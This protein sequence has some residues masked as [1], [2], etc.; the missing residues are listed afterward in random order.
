MN[1][2]CR[3]KFH[4]TRVRA[5]SED[6]RNDWVEEI[7][8]A[9]IE[10]KKRFR[11]PEPDEDLDE[12]DEELPGDVEPLFFPNSLSLVCQVFQCLRKTIF[13]QIIHRLKIAA[14]N[15]LQQTVA[16]TVGVAGLSFAGSF[17]SD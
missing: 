14:G 6:I 5:S 15:F 13:Q 12:P 9:I 16:I 2:D 4:L 17:S 7:N 3:L 1:K 10:I 11:T 8:A